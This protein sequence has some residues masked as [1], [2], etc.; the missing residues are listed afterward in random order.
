MLVITGTSIML[1]SSE[2]IVM[3]FIRWGI[4]TFSDIEV[5]LTY[6]MPG[7]LSILNTV[8]NL[9]FRPEF[10]EQ[11]LFLLGARPSPS[12]K[13]TSRFVKPS[14]NTMSMR[15]VRPRIVIEQH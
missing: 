8:I 1:I 4:Y 11:L 13:N 10:R 12:S 14:T 5:A 3:I 15:M 6:A 9:S 7:F 2:S